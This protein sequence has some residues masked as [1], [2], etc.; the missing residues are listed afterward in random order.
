[1]KYS[2]VIPTFNHCD[3]L[4]KPCIESIYRN[5]DLSD[6]EIIVVAN[7]CTDNTR[8]YIESLDNKVRL[9]WSEKALG[10]T[11]ATN[12]GILAAHGEYVLLLNN[13]TEIL[14][15]GKNVW[16]SMMTTPFIN[17]PKM[18]LTGTLKLHDP[19][20][21][22]DFIVFSCVLIKREIFDKLGILDEVF[23][24]GYGEDIDFCMKVVENGYQWH[25]V[26]ETKQ[27]GS[28]HVGTF[29][30][31]HKGTQTFG[32]IPEYGNIIVKKNA[33]ILRERYVNKKQI[34][35]NTENSIRYSIIIP[36]Y[37]HCDDLLRPC[38]DSIFKYTNMAEVELIISAN[39]CVDNTKEYL[40][41]LR[42]QF[43]SLG[44]TNNLKIVW[45]DSALG[46]ARA[47]NEAIKVATTNK[48][49]LLNNDVVLLVQDRS[50]W[51]K[52]LDEP[53]KTNP[54]A[55]ISC[56]I[57]GPSAPAGHDFAVFFC[58]MIHKKVFDAIGLLNEEYGVGGGEDTE[59]CIET[60]RAGFEVCLAQ[61]TQWSHQVGMY[62]G[63]FPIYHKGEGTMHDSNLV[64][65]HNT[66]FIQN[67]LRLARKYNH[68]WYRL[69]ASNHF[70]RAVFLPGDPVLPC[71][72]AR[73]TWAS[74]NLLG[75]K[76]FELGCSNGY[77]TQYFPKD[78][79]YTGCDYDPLI[80]WC[81]QNDGWGNH[82]K[83]VNA[84]INTYQLDYYD[85][86]IAFEVIEHLENGLE[87]VERFKN[88]CNR[89]LITVP[90]ME[91]PGFWG[92]YHKLHMLNESHF[93][94]FKYNY[95]DSHGVI[96]ETLRPVSE[97]N[98]YNLLIMSWTKQL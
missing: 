64:P 31:W 89:L 32:N 52:L 56:V 5:T 3:D 17:N 66:V 25:C 7:G 81:A 91:S 83:F 77:G 22:Q 68:D 93:E 86:I 33:A 28:L 71:E 76:I 40:Q 59:F 94:G 62:T 10:Y 24:P 45:N 36:T 78:I 29:P 80:I 20:I 90:H 87:L 39:G 49:I 79:D 37:N 84:D 73:Y 8:E 16:L 96:T 1:M 47:C 61:E 51:I 72:H 97:E 9:I 13:D 85:T 46:Y 23:S 14:D 38:V 18:A 69:T 74:Q 67:S 60:E 48:I 95:I 6:V 57:K 92:P 44:F 65:N 34:E 63:T 75:N 70:E 88:H 42:N 53:F 55:G 15:Y 12:L 82:C 43:D 2:I 4:L 21:N 98:R 35:I 54:K 27:K 50:S 11:K 58:V 26:D 41:L 19:D 30:L